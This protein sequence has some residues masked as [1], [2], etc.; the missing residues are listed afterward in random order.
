VDGTVPGGIILA[1]LRRELAE[2]VHLDPAGEPG[3]RGLVSDEST[4]VGRVH[5][6]LIYELVCKS[7]T[8]EIMEKDKIEGEWAGRR[9]IREHYG[10][11]ESWSRIVYDRYIRR[12]A[13]GER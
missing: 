7:G 12:T 2:E 13:E 4:E 8:F 6:G 5:L 10:A 1:G 11:F 9:W 3:L